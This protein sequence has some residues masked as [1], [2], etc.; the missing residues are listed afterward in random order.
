MLGN[1]TCGVILIGERLYDIFFKNRNLFES[2]KR[3]PINCRHSGHPTVIDAIQKIS[4]VVS[5][6]AIEVGNCSW[7]KKQAWVGQIFYCSA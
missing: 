3:P 7:L 1:M 4:Q 2:Q 6:L 5:R